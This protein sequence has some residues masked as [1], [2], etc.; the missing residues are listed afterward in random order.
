M[1]FSRPKMSDFSDIMIDDHIEKQDD[2]V[3]P[4]N[5]IMFIF[6]GDANYHKYFEDPEHLL[7]MIEHMTP[8]YWCAK[9]MPLLHRISECIE[10]EDIEVKSVAS[11][12]HKE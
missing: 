1:T 4:L 6:L 8:Q 10:D 11:Q 5:D 9:Y 12:N 2:E 7:N 3:L